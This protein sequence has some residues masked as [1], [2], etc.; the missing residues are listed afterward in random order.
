[1]HEIGD[2]RERFCE[3]CEKITRQRLIAQGRSG[4]SE[5]APPRKWWCIDGDHLVD[6]RP[7]PEP[8]LQEPD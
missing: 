5:V 3:L 6:A 4:S 8:R 1:M 2:V 7:K